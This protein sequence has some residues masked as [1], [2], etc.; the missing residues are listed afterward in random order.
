MTSGRGVAEE[1][2]GQRAQRPAEDQEPAQR[3]VTTLADQV[4]DRIAGQAATE[5][6][7]AGGAARRLL[8]VALGSDD[9]HGPPHVRCHVDGAIVT[10]GVQL[11]VRYPEAIADVTD[12][13]RRRIVDRVRQL[14]GL[15]VR[16]VDITVTGLL[17]PARNSRAVR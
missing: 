7:A 3:G 6:D 5:V 15:E 10:V 8:G 12:A 13:V 14:T 4:V 2:R 9:P 17:A 16:Q 11:S 1:E